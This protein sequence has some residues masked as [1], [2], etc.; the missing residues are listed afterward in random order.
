[1]TCGKYL[2]NND[3]V[4]CSKCP[5]SYHRSCLAN[6]PTGK[7]SSWLCEV[8]KPRTPSGS[9]ASPMEDHADSHEID[10]GS[11]L[12]SFRVEL[13]AMRSE[14]RELRAEMAEFRHSIQSCYNRMD[15]LDERMGKLE[16]RFEDTHETQHSSLLGTIEDLK[17]QL[18]E[19]EQDS[20]ANDIEIAGVPE[21]NG[22]QPNHLLSLLTIKLGVQIDERDVMYAERAG[23]VRRNRSESGDVTGET[24]Q[25]PR[26]IVVRF[27]RRTVRDSVLRAA[28]VRR[29]LTAADLEVRGAAAQ[30]IYV[31]ERLSRVNRS[32]FYKA[33]EAGRRMKWRYVW[34]KDGRI[35]ARKDIGK[36][37]M[38]IKCESDIARIFGVH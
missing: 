18:N 9:Q 12:R 17:R 32:L 5:G 36:P 23:I 34:T 4:R 33:R 37:A 7:G 21:E 31:N 25:R 29:D 2:S 38:F 24:M 8:C 1:M 28:R 11:E 26:A 30:R 13:G 10:L 15:S 35:L 16:K 22:E 19:R 27:T 14:L 3:C 6:P 20:L